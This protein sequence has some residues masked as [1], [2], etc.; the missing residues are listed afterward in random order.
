MLKNFRKA[1]FLSYKAIAA[2]LCA[3]AVLV[4]TPFAFADVIMET[5]DKTFSLDTPPVNGQQ[6]A[7]HP[8][9]NPH[10]RQTNNIQYFI[11]IGELDWSQRTNHNPPRR[12]EGKPHRPR[13]SGAQSPSYKGPQQS[14]VKGKILAPAR[15]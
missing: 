1:C 10:N 5:G 6:S 3:L 14:P 12:E 13:P 15:Q 4:P 11:D 9:L 7:T 2:A 8:E